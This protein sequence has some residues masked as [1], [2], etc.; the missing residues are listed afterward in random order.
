MKLTSPAEPAPMTIK[1]YSFPGFFPDEK[2]EETTKIFHT[3]KNLSIAIN[4][5]FQCNQHCNFY[6]I[7][8]RL[9]R[10]AQTIYLKKKKLFIRSNEYTFR[11]KLIAI[12]FRP[13]IRW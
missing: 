6:S 5:H 11:Q 9:F 12:I 13:Q 4:A 8:L 3:L 7:Y 2:K 10:F 1:S